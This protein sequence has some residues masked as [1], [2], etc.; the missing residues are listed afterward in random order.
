VEGTFASPLPLIVGVLAGI[1]VGVAWT[2]HH[3]VVGRA[4]GQ[5]GLVAGRILAP[6][7][8]LPGAW[9]TNGSDQPVYGVVAWVVASGGA[10]PATGEEWVRTIGSTATSGGVLHGP[11]EPS[12]PVLLPLLPPGV[13]ALELP[14]WA[15]SGSAGRP[16][17]EMGF[18]DARGRHWIRRG[19]GRLAAIDA[20]AWR[21]YG[22]SAPDA[23]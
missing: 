13:V 10:A 16:A 9:L 19:S 8:R 3:E 18:S 22:L 17:I 14:A 4:Q 23:V 7:A 2:V 11:R 15:R 5:A 1:V 20:P 6:G 12:T 21:H